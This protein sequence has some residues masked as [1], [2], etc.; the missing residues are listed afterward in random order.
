VRT[1]LRTDDLAEAYRTRDL[2]R[3]NGIAA[4]VSV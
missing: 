3:E 2:L 4:E 1:V